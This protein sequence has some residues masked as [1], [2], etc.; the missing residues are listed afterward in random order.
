MSYLRQ[1][2]RRTGTKSHPRARLRRERAWTLKWRR[3]PRALLERS[4]IATLDLRQRWDGTRA[5]VRG[6][7][8]E[9]EL[10]GVWRWIDDDDEWARL[11][12][13]APAGVAGY[14]QFGQSFKWVS[15]PSVY[16]NGIEI[17]SK[18]IVWVYY[19]IALI[20]R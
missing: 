3:R 20:I 12:G 9:S 18:Y 19:S 15:S 16:S 5:R 8:L 6:V 17:N 14:T 13:G 11:S 10:V 2:H 1:Y 4:Q 7:E